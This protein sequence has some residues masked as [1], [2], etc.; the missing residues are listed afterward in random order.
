MSV[1]FVSMK[2]II[3]IGPPKTGTT[4]L[5]RA[6][7][8]SREELL[9]HG[10]LYP[11]PKIRKAYN[12]GNL[13]YLFRPFSEAPRGM[14][15]KGEAHYIQQGKA[16][17]SQVEQ[18]TR[19]RRPDVLIL[20]SEWFARAYQAANTKDFIAFAES[21]GAESI[22]FVLYARRPSEFFLSASQ[23]RLRAS[24]L[25]QPIYPWNVTGL[26]EGFRSF[27]KQ[28]KVNARSFDRD[29]LTEGNIVADFA[30][31]YIPTCADV[32]KNAKRG[33][34]SNESFSAEVMVILQDFRRSFFADQ[35]DVFNERTRKLMRKLQKLDTRDGNPRPKLRSEW[36]DYLDYGDDRALELRKVHDIAFSNFDYGRLERG[37]F[38]RKPDNASDVADIVEIDAERVRRLLGDL[39]RSNWSLR[40]R[41]DIWLRKLSIKM[42]H[43][44]EGRSVLRR[45]F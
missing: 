11:D 8:N 44:Y 23:Q 20:S 12:H 10:V 40:R 37:E 30:A 33:S 9:K 34:Q 43:P 28:H 29:A 36:K 13:C 24:S 32:L 2:L 17:R 26:I 39:E 35:E 42:G 18:Q 5:Q 14:K 38:A 45:L 27:A 1:V 25:F 16:L 21:L 19:D 6:L 7:F 4:A 31:Q 15:K 22:E 41:S 3:H